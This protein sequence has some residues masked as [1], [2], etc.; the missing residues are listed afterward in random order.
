MPFKTQLKVLFTD[1]GQA[2]LLGP[3]VYHHPLGEIIV[4]ENFITDFA[5]V[6]G[7][8]LL[9][10]VVPRVGRIRWAAVVHDWI[11]RGHEGERFTR[12]EADQILY[13]AAIEQ[14][15]NAWRAKAAWLGVRIGG[16]VPWSKHHK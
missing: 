1:D 4:M 13:D 6:P 9:P 5:S 3:L 10:G 15:M 16:W 14:G 2:E 12:G 11:Y 8:V 7:Y